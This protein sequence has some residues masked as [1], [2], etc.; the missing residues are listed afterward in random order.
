MQVSN[1]TP[2]TACLLIAEPSSRSSP[3]CALEWLH[4]S[5][6]TK[7][8]H[9]IPDTHSWDD[10]PC[11]LLNHFVWILKPLTLSKAFKVLIHGVTETPMKEHSSTWATRWRF[12]L[13]FES[14]YG[15]WISMWCS[16]PFFLVIKWHYDC[17]SC[18]NHG[19]L[20]ISFF[21]LSNPLFYRSSFYSWLTL[22]CV[23]FLFQQNGALRIT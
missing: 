4:S 15:T 20:N 23:L 11:I 22:K 7:F 12:D 10:E 17:A 9:L 2:S 13:L 14:L 3:K 8:A 1:K 16:W 6:E 19:M 18:H 21:Q 5:S